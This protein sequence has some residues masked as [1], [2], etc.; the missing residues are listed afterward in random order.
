MKDTLQFLAVFMITLG[1]I[2]LFMAF[3]M[4]VKDNRRA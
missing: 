2:R 4:F 3:I 1:I